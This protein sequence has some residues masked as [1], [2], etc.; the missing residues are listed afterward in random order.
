MAAPLKELEKQ[1]E[2]AIR[3]IEPNL[4]VKPGFSFLGMFSGAFSAVATAAFMGPQMLGGAFNWL[5]ERKMLSGVSGSL[6]SASNLAKYPEKPLGEVLGHISSAV[7]KSP[8]TEVV[9]KAPGAAVISR[10]SDYAK[11]TLPA[12][13]KGKLLEASAGQTLFAGSMVVGQAAQTVSTFS[14]RMRALK[15]MQRDLTGE[16]P[17]TLGILLG[18]SKLHPL[19]KSVR[20]EANGLRA[21]AATLLDVAGM[22]GNVLMLFDRSGGVKWFAKSMALG[23]GTS[24]VSSVI[25]SGQTALKGYSDMTLHLANNGK[26]ELED[27][28]NATG[29]L[30]PKADA[31]MVQK[32]AEQAFAKQMK[33]PEFLKMMSETTFMNAPA[34]ALAANDHAAAAKPVTIGGK[35]FTP[36]AMEQG[37]VAAL[38]AQ[39]ANDAQ[40]AARTA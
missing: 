5:S 2:N 31:Q 6:K 24:M 38:A 40:R 7:S 19:V 21:N 14:G 15:Q 26:I 9:A 16:T 12:G 35:T 18:T 27:Y 8:I 33:P 29:G 22:A 13:M 1:S 25:T 32:V 4:L 20:G 30:F 34:S 37:H 39:A 17:S 3:R 10:V 36:K 28:V 11:K 23:M